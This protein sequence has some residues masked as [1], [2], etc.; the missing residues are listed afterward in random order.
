[1]PLRKASTITNVTPVLGAASKSIATLTTQPLIVSKVTLQSKPRPGHPKFKG[2]MEVLRYILAHEGLRGLFKGLGPQ[3]G[4]GLLVQ[5][6][7]MMSKERIEV[8]F[9]ALFALLRKLRAQR[10]AE[11]AAKAAA[12]LPK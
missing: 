5:G 11:A 12:V 2:F 10:L 6:I 4:K 1:Q 9:I 8:L 7:L 3:L